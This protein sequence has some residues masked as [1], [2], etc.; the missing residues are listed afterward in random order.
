MA[1]PARIDLQAVKRPST[2]N[3]YLVAPEGYC[4]SAKTDAGAPVFPVSPG[5]LWEIL[6]SVVA[7]EPRI[8]VHWDDAADGYF[9]FT[10]R[11]LV[12]RFPDRVVIK[13]LPGAQLATSTLAI[14]S[15]AVYGRRDLGVN[16]ARVERLLG[17]IAQR[18]S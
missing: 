2:P 4:R 13:V 7:R 18:A 12:F 10:Q 5:T 15:R 16:R 8:T 3:S 9:D 6:V 11:S 1:R 17:G 14:Y